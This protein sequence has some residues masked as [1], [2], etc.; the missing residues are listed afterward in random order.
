MQETTTVKSIINNRNRD[1]LSCRIISGCGLIGSGLYV[2]HH[3]KKFQ[4]TIGKTVMYSIGSG[5][6]FIYSFSSFNKYIEMLPPINLDLFIRKNEI[7]CAVHSI[8]I[9]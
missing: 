5:N 2:S 1:C 7:L 9:D 3:S 4:K 8:Y 6:S